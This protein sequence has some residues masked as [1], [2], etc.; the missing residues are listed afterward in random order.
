MKT[1]II[2]I[3]LVLAGLLM[4][5]NPFDRKP[6]NY[7]RIDKKPQEYM[8]QVSVTTY[9]EVGQLKNEL[10]AHYWAYLPELESSNLTKPHLT[11]YKADGTIWHIDAKEG[12]ASQPTL[13]AI[14][15]IQ[16]KNDVVLQRQA[17]RNTY[18]IRLETTAL[19]YQP[20][21]Q[22][23]ETDQFI[24]MT[25]PGLKITGRGLRAFIEQGTVELLHNVT[26]LYTKATS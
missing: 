4:L 10:S 15:S 6:H 26:T 3:I 1:N 2:L 9:T 25:K 11:V 24:T 19:N 23:A 17:S 5:I 14:D 21:K 18:P 13:G 12:A 8:S 20:K 16:L 7:F 22:Y